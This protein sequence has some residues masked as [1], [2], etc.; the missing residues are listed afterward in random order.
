[1][2]HLFQK[3]IKYISKSRLCGSK[4]LKKK[5]ERNLKTNHCFSHS[6]TDTRTSTCTE[7]DFSFEDIRFENCCWFH[8]WYFILRRWHG[9]RN[10]EAFWLVVSLS[11]SIKST[12][13]ANTGYWQRPMDLFIDAFDFYCHWFNDTHVRIW[14]SLSSMIHLLLSQ[15]LYRRQ[16]E[17][18]DGF[19]SRVVHTC[20]DSQLETQPLASRYV[21]KSE[22]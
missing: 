8:D 1:M 15:I 12:C 14:Q 9:S 21:A 20:R 17:A 7:K 6:T 5:K 4:G 18:D 13:S 19:L 10:C 2:T 11:T 22:R 16:E 3:S